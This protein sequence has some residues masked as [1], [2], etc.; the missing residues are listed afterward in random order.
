MMKKQ[1][2]HKTQ[3]VAA[4][5]GGGGQD[6]GGGQVWWWHTF[7]PNSPEAEAGWGWFTHGGQKRA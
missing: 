2:G 4:R 3:R 1:V 7:N 5:Y 6:G